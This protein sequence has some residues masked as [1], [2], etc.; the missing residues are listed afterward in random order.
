MGHADR[1]LLESELARLPWPQ[2]R[3]LRLVHYADLTHVQV[4][5]RTG[6]PLGTVKSH[7]RRG[8]AELRRR[9]AEH[10]SSTAFPGSG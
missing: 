9:L 10:G 7:V 1:L 8:L 3:V 5:E 6:L 2:L 4:A